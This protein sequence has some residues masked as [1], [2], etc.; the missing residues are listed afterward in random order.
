MRRR[1]VIALLALAGAWAAWTAWNAGG[2]VSGADQGDKE[3]AKAVAL[4]LLPPPLLVGTA[5]CSARGCHG[6]LGPASKPADGAA[7]LQDE[8]GR[9]LG[10]DKHARAYAVLFEP[11]SQQISLHLYG[12]P[13]AHRQARCLAC[14]T[15]TSAA[16]GYH[17]PE[18]AFGVGCEACHGNASAWLDRHTGARWKELSA[19]DKALS[20]MTNLRDPAAVAYT[21]AGCHVGAAA[22]ARHGDIVRDMNHDLIAA[23]HPRLNFEFSAYLANLPPHWNVA[24]SDKHRPPEAELWAFGQLVSAEAALELLADRAKRSQGGSGLPT[25]A[26]PAPWPELAEYDCYACHHD[27]TAKSWRLERG[28]GKHTPGSLPW[29]T[30]YYPLAKRLVADRW[31]KLAAL[32]SE[33]RKPLPKAQEVAPKAKA[34]QTTLGATSLFPPD[35]PDDDGERQKLRKALQFDDARLRQLLKEWL[36][37][38]K[39]PLPQTWEAAE[40]VF[41]AGQ[42]LKQPLDDRELLEYRALGAGGSPGPAFQPKVFLDKVRDRLPK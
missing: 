40:Q 15:N 13:A 5:A 27:L 39:R 36:S 6:A 18:R 26:F 32:E 11:K 21:C 10:N 8:Y 12:T 28:Y 25:D 41:L 9:W 4:T 7:V 19:A 20:G 22:H 23:G 35:N 38:T 33:M 24:F 3:P 1:H 16:A 34:A 2:P 31:D 17:H 42:C 14:H 37:D 29:G 30:W